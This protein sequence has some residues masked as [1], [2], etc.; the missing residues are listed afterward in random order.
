MNHTIDDPGEDTMEHVKGNVV[1]LAGVVLLSQSDGMIEEGRGEC[2][3]TLTFLN[4]IEEFNQLHLRRCSFP[5][6]NEEVFLRHIFF[7]G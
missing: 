5:V 6:W 4:F 3:G 7:E 1:P 2:E